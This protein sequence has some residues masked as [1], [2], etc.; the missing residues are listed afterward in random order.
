MISTN[1]FTIPFKP[2]IVYAYKY[3]EC[4]LC[5]YRKE[6]DPEYTN[7]DCSA[8]EKKVFSWKLPIKEALNPR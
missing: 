2:D 6:I 7:F 8:C 1:S 5:T 4:A 3:N